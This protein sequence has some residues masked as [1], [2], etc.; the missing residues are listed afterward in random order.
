MTKHTTAGPWEVTEDGTGVKS[1][2]ADVKIFVESEVASGCEAHANARLAASAPEMFDLLERLEE[3]AEY[4]SEN[5]V[6]I[7]IVADIKSVLKKARGK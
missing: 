6:P 7:G 3:S 1:T 4:W 2:K 5:D